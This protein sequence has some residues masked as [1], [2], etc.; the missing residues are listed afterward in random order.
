MEWDGGLH[1]SPPNIPKPSVFQIFGLGLFG[2]QRLLTF[3][4]EKQGL[5]NFF[6]WGRSSFTSVCSSGQARLSITFQYLELEFLSINA[7]PR[8]NFLLLLF[9]LSLQPFKQVTEQET[10][11]C[12]VAFYCQS[13]KGNNF[14]QGMNE[15][16]FGLVLIHRQ[17]WWCYLCDIWM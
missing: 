8:T 15:L 1:F 16:L 6:V 14:I 5:Q 9:S 3:A 13:T 4:L 12:S 11:T 2:R 10:A 17:W 7:T